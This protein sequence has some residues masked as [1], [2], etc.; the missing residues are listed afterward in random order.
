DG[1]T[2]VVT[3][4]TSKDSTSRID[5]STDPDFPPALTFNKTNAAFVTQHNLT[6]TGLTPNA[7]YYFVVSSVDHDGNFA[8]LTAPSFTVPGP[9]LH[10]TA[11]VDFLAGTPDANAYIA[12]TGD[13]EVI[14]KPSFGSEFSGKGLETGW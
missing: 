2:A 13:G 11:S 1:S 10:D 9:T 7:T 4:K 3:W 12:E 5:Y 6:L 8:M 14:L